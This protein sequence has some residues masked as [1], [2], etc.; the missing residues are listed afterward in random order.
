MFIGSL[1]Y[2]AISIA[3]VNYAVKQMERQY[4]ELTN[5]YRDIL[6]EAEISEITKDGAMLNTA[7]EELERG[8][9]IWSRV[10]IGLIIGA[11]LVIDFIGEDPHLLKAV[12]S[13]LGKLCEAAFLGTP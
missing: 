8:K 10:W 6:S 5:H 7:R 12:F 1:V 4:K 11:F 3:E 9:R 2:Y 13:F